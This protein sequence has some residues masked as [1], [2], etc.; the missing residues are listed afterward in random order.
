MMPGCV[1]DVS[2]ADF[3]AI[4]PTRLEYAGVAPVESVPV[5]VTPTVLP[6]SAATRV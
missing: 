4:G 6:A 5:T 3:A 2:G 1:V